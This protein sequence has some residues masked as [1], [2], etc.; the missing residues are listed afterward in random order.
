[1]SYTL[2]DKFGNSNFVFKSLTRE[3]F[4]DILF[5]YEIKLEYVYM[6]EHD[7][8]YFDEETG[9]E[10]YTMTKEYVNFVHKFLDMLDDD[11]YSDKAIIHFFNENY[12]PPYDH[13][14][15]YKLCWN[16]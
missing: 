6:N 1:M 8:Y 10:D 4:E 9:E 12:N 15:D 2:K 5:S 11:E 14:S 16:G 3:V 13:M 7:C